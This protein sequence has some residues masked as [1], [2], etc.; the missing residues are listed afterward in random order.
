MTNAGGSFD[1]GF[2]IEPATSIRPHQVMTGVTQLT[3]AAASEVIPGPND[4]PF[5]YDHTNTHVLAA[6]AKVDVTPIVALRA[7]VAS[8]ALNRARALN[9]ATL[10]VVLDPSDPAGRPLVKKP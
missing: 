6:A 1:N 10:S 4:Y 2:A 3:V 7:P 5:L 9:S 8:P